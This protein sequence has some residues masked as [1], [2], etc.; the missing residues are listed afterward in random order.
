MLKVGTV[1]L[2]LIGS[3]RVQPQL[4]LHKIEDGVAPINPEKVLK[5]SRTVVQV[6]HRDTGGGPG[7]SSTISYLSEDFLRGQFLAVWSVEA[8]Q[9][10]HS[11]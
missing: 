9:N 6:R 11:P 3:D 1:S 4:E 5:Y 10:Q 7:N 2:D 8:L